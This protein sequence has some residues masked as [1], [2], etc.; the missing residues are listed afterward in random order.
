M[1]TLGAVG[2]SWLTHQSFATAVFLCVAAAIA[3]VI[4]FLGRKSENVNAPRWVSS[5]AVAG[6]HVS[7]AF[8]L[9]VCGTIAFYGYDGFLYAIGA[10][11][12]VVVLRFFQRGKN[13]RGASG[14]IVEGLNSRFPSNGLRRVAAISTLACGTIFLVPHVVAALALVKPL[15]GGAFVGVALLALLLPV[16]SMSNRVGARAA[17]TL[18][19]VLL[20]GVL[21][22]AVMR[23]GLHAKAENVFPR[24]LSS[25]QFRAQLQPTDRVLPNNGPWRGRYYARAAPCRWIALRVELRRD[26][27]VAIKLA[28]GNVYRV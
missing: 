19:L 28:G 7:A 14:S 10:V 20:V 23:R 3:G 4:V 6:N 21:A 16:A 17:G 15:G 18:L 5:L 12:G 9:G 8:F 26:A 2:Y 25:A 22:I 27:A 1:K 11:A 13:S 24:R